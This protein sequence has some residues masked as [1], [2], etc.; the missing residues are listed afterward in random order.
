MSGT[1]Q[2][3]YTSKSLDCI[4]SIG[5]FFFPTV[6]S[7]SDKPDVT[8]FTTETPGNAVVLG[9]K[10]TLTCSANG[11]PAPTYT[12]KRGG[13]TLES[14]SISGKHVINSVQLSHEDTPYSCEPTNDIG[15]G[16]RKDLNIVVQG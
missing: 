6:I 3:M 11:Y 16:P 10:V 7:F 5:S 8:N 4:G 14:Q 2:P 15:N 12:I 9:T 13:S 1:D